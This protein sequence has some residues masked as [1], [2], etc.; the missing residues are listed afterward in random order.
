MFNDIGI[1]E[2]LGYQ[3]IQLYDFV[4]KEYKKK[5]LRHDANFKDMVEKVIDTFEE[6]KRLSRRTIFEGDIVT[7]YDYTSSFLAYEKTPQ[8]QAFHV[9]HLELV[10]QLSPKAL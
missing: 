2:R 6:G 10:A 1:R 3:T 8:S 7:C 4:L 9:H 5:R